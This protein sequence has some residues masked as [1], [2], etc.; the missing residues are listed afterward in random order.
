MEDSATGA[1]AAA[2]SATSPIG[3]ASS[4]AGPETAITGAS[5]FLGARL[6]RELLDRGHRLVLLAHA[7][8]GDALARL[9]RFLA[10]SGAPS[11]MIN[12]LRGRVREVEVDIAQPLLGLPADAFH[13]LAGTLGALWHSAADTTLAGAS[14]QL[15]QVNV[16][17]TRHVLDLAAAAPGQPAVFHVSTAFIAGSR[18]EE[19]AYEDDLDGTQGFENSYERSKFDGEVLVRQWSADTGRPVVVFRPSL[20]LTDVPS[21]PDLP[22]H[23]LDAVARAVLTIVSM[24]AQLDLGG[25]GT[26]EADRSTVRVV[27]DPRARLNVMPVEEAAR[28]M[29]HIAGHAP[30]DGVMTYHIV[31]DSDLTVTQIM[32]LFEEFFP[33]HLVAVPEPPR[34]QTELE[35]MVDL[36][37][38]FVS[39]LLHRHVFD[40]TRARTVLGERQP[41][42]SIDRQYLLA[43]LGVGELVDR[44]VLD[45]PPPTPATG[46]REALDRARAVRERRDD[47]QHRFR[48][49]STARPHA[50]EAS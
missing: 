44:A 18:R 9:G 19:V 41:S 47:Q 20:L 45:G 2:R 22:P 38:G 11:S 15:H 40:D 29:V 5:G 17:G 42:R 43:A 7:G 46:G 28:D 21:H 12:G 14:E 23:T 32:L 8:S 39:Y 10:A 26:G 50:V 6:A 27:A 37:P 35:R 24:A 30:S 33:A 48:E 3:Y 31:G 13:E 1:A 4:R 34:D 25:G 49:P 36:V 16:E